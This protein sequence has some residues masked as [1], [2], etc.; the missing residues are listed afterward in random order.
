MA[1]V[2]ST[3]SHTVPRLVRFGVFEVDV[4]TRELRKNG[5]QIRLQEQP[6]Q[7]LT[8]LL[9]HPGEMVAREELR[10]RLWPA[11]TFVDFDNSV[12][13]AVNR[14]REALGDSAENP[15]FI[16]TLPR[17]GYR[18]IAPVDTGDGPRSVAVSAPSSVEE[19]LPGS[20]TP[21]F[22]LHSRFSI[23]GAVVAVIL[24]A[25]GAYRWKA[26][27]QARSAVPVSIQ[28]IVV[29][30]LQNLTGDPSQNDFVDGLTDLLTAE[31]AQGTSLRVISRTSAMHYKG[32]TKRLFEIA[33]ELNVN[34][35]VEGAVAGSTDRVRITAQ[36]IYAPADQHIWAQSYERDLRELPALQPQI[37]SDLIRAIAAPVTSVQRAQ[38]ARVGSGNPEAYSLYLRAKS[39]YGVETRAA[40]DA[41]IRLLERSVAD[42]PGFADAWAALATAYR[43]RAFNITPK[44]K[45]WQ[46]KA[47]GAVEKALVLDPGLAEAYVARG[48]LLWSKANHFA[49]ERAVMDYR[50]ALQLN[51][52]LAEAH[53]QLANIYNHVGLFERAKSEI[54]KAVAIDPLNTGARYR[55]GINL[56]YQG[57]YQESLSAIRDSQ[58]FNPPLWT[59][60]TSYALFQLG[61]QEEAR[62]RVELF[63]Q[64]NPTD[65]GGGLAAMEALLAASAHDRVAANVQINR[66]IVKGEGF[67]HFHHSAYIIASA[68][69]LMKEPDQALRFLQMAADGG[70]PCYPLFETDPNLNT[71]RKDP[72]FVQFMTELR[73]Q[74]EH[75]QNTL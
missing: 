50:R 70:F 58:D 69:A 22:F 28:S 48:Y 13:A 57:K 10:K 60:Q 45:D 63:L 29:L 61:R 72:R 65:P 14:L 37:A 55:V 26:G 4:R 3:G 41:A 1:T 16:Q 62:R 5:V 32:T 71:L 11:D 30:P 40:N 59:L 8:A 44:E 39:Y 24:L 35:V 64:D 36:L 74:W 20:R 34:A 15:R 75:Y 31:L 38:L 25:L 52:S 12:N 49:C 18:F 23:A 43:V 6:F 27:H 2:E 47:V 19:V 42:D 7:I 17:R 51:P 56:L 68:Y 67:Q 54:D 73:S 21:S 66:A 33:R 53:H 46:E 9:E